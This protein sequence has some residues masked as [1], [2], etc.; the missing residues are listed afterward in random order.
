[1]DRVIYECNG[2]QI[3]P[4]NRQLSRAGVDVPLEPKA[5]AVLVVLLGR[6]D[7]L[8][9]R[10]DLLDAV[11][12]HRCVTPA[13]LN[14]V[15]TL[16]RRVFDD[17]ADNPRAIRTVH[18][19]GYRFIAAIERSTVSRGEARAR[20][21]PPPVARL[22]AKLEPLVGRER[23]L[24][25][26]GEMLEQH[27]AVTILGAGGMGKTQCALEAARLGSARFADGVWFFDLSPIEQAQEW[28]VTLAAA[29]SVPTARTP[30]LL[31]RIAAALA[32]R[33][34]QLVIDNCDRL[35]AEIGAIVLTLLRACPKLKILATSRQRLDFVGEHLMWLPPLQLPPLAA[36]ARRLP[37]S[38]IA[39]IP[40]V[41]LLLMRAAAV[42]PAIVLSATNID[43]IVEICR[44]LDGM[45][46]ALELVA[47][48]FAMLSSVAI[49]ERLQQQVGLPASDSAGR[50]RRHQ[51]LHALVDWSYGLLSPPEQRLLCWLGVF[52]QG[53]TIDAAE[54]IGLALGIASER[55]LHLHS[56]LILK[57]LVVVDPS[58]APPRYRLLETVRDYA[59]ALLRR[60][61]EEDDARRAHLAHFAQLA[62]R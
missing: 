58:L 14:R 34:C 30:Q 1:V 60:R 40:A 36:E 2:L 18:G 31:E 50:E 25:Q 23:E 10:D 48:Q 27:R 12:G 4:V 46:L 7:E 52:L 56:G 28:L 16:L 19:A 6:A 35:A 17:D 61:G 51:T 62:E 41:E 20:F 13:T 3:D 29:L 39:T 45:P 5:F 22:P 59:L 42:Q 47:A 38:W 49:R 32:T 33:D 11:W 37:I 9:T 55:L 54:N 8:V 24:E 21:G 26:L 57:S 15:M 53:W 44:R 43:D